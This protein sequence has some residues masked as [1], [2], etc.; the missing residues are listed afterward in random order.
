MHWAVVTACYVSFAP[1]LLSSR[2][3]SQ[4]DVSLYIS[5]LIQSD[6]LW[7]WS[8]LPSGRSQVMDQFQ[9]CGLVDGVSVGPVD[10]NLEG[11]LDGGEQEGIE[12]GREG[13]MWDW[14]REKGF[15]DQITVSHVRQI[16]LLKRTEFDCILETVTCWGQLWRH[17]QKLSSVPD[18]VHV[19]CI[20][21]QTV[22]A[23]EECVTSITVGCVMRT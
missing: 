22:L 20:V 7:A 10:T 17:C 5:L 8:L 15:R 2:E 18:S 13:K 16:L 12:R 4:G 9:C 14:E 6:H 11:L 21:F 1:H 23:T 3:S 19:S